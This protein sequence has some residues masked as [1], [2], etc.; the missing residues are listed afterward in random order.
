MEDDSPQTCQKV[1]DGSVMTADVSDLATGAAQVT[2]ATGAAQ[3]T[4]ATPL[5]AHHN[6]AVSSCDFGREHVADGAEKIHVSEMHAQHS[7]TVLAGHRAEVSTS[8]TYRLVSAGLAFSVWGGWGYFVN[9]QETA[10]TTSPLISGLLHGLFSSMVTIVMLT[11]VTWLYRRFAA[12]GVWMLI[13]AVTTSLVTGSCITSAHV[14]IGTANVPATV[15][16]GLVVAFCFNL[17]T[18]QK[19][20]QADQSAAA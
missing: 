4:S 13:P 20:H 12:A 3:V 7:S 6:I 1:G 8:W 10:P 2:A 17:V 15:I 18:T 5:N 14:I 16:P 19:L 9:S 11:S